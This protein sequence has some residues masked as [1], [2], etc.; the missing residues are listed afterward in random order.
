M[1]NCIFLSKARL[2][3]TLLNK[4]IK[5]QGGTA[6]ACTQRKNKSVWT[7]VGI[8]IAHTCES[9]INSAVK[10]SFYRSWIRKVM[11]NA[12]MCLS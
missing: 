5:V 8:N 2:T 3:F 11:N 7:L 12:G 4:K 10:T 6:I 9:N 1:Q